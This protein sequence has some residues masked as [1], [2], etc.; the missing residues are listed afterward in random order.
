MIT[1]QNIQALYKKYA[2]RANSIDTLDMEL[3]YDAAS[4]NH[5]VYVD[6]ETDKLV[7]MSVDADSPFH[8]IPLS[9]IHAIVPF[10]QWIAI[11]LHSSIIFLNRENSQVA[12]DIK[13]VNLG[14]LDRVRQAVSAN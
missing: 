8:A 3:L 12:V 4:E 10:E 7:I 1:R 2:K 6:P 14:L 13:P 9:K 11:V 5:G